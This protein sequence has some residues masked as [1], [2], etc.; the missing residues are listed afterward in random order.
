MSRNEET[1]NRRGTIYSMAQ[2]IQVVTDGHMEDIWRV[3]D[4]EQGNESSAAE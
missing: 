2:G 1:E 3:G 4:W